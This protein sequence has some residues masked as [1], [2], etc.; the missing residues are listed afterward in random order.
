M[1]CSMANAR[2]EESKEIADIVDVIPTV[3]IARA[4]NSA[5]ET[6]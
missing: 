1:Q 2:D 5:Y 3:A 6:S 4:L